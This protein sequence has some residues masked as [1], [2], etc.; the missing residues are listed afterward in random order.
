MKMSSEWRTIE[1]EAAHLAVLLAFSSFFLVR[2]SLY[3]APISRS[4]IDSSGH[5]TDEEANIFIIMKE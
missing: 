5:L 2:I 4:R 1:A 3:M